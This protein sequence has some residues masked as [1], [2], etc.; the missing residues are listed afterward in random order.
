MRQVVAYKKLKKKKKTR[1]SLG[2][3]GGRGRLHFGV[4]DLPGRLWEVVAYERWSLMKVR[5]YL[6]NFGKIFL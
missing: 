4:L 5:L 6:V 1:K 2:P 3:K